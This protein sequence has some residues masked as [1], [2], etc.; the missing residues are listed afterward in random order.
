[1]IAET[2]MKDWVKWDSGTSVATYASRVSV[3]CTLVPAVL[4]RAVMLVTA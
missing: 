1:M 2:P 4:E 3:P